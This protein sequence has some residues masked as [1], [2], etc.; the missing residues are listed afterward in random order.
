MSIDNPLRY[1]LQIAG[2]E[3]EVREVIGSEEL[4]GAFRFEVRRRV[5]EGDELNP[6]EL[7][8][9]ELVKGDAVLL[10]RR[11]GL[12]V[13][14]IVA[15]VTDASIEYTLGS[16]AELSLVLEPRLS[17]LNF[18]QDIR[19]FR[20]KD[21]PTIVSEVMSALGVTVVSKLTES[22][23][24]RPYCVQ[25]R[26]TDYHFA[27]RLLEEEGIFYYFDENGAVVL[28]D[29]PGAYHSLAAP[30]T[31]FRQEAAMNVEGA[32]WSI[33]E[34]ASTGVSAITLRDWNPDTPSL[35]MD[36]SAPG[37]CPS[38]REYYDYPGEY[39]TPDGG[40]RFASRL[41]DAHHSEA[42]SQ[43]GSSSR[44]DFAPGY[45]FVL[46]DPPPGISPG[47]RV[48]R[49]VRHRWDRASG[50]FSLQY[51]ASP[52]SQVVRPK[53]RHPEPCVPNLMTGFVT[54]PPGEDIHTD[55]YGRVKV[56]FHWDRLLGRW[57]MDHH[58]Y[59][60]LG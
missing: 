16:A 58:Q 44:A 19:L 11:D 38:G 32:V 35:N 29:N 15:I 3:L 46:S 37:P 27:N 56:Q 33:G 59:T 4:S 13:R 43:H 8:P 49:S 53:I 60:H 55:E 10:L 40:R 57:L 24:V 18:R 34:R 25:L 6:D 22:Y 50:S 28:G 23:P 45:T 1:F 12:V 26:E 21:A 7:D 30:E 51:S 14:R 9:D 42:F 41:A 5:S 17:L 20:D 39:G 52:G 47:E 2:R 48:I 31:P 36:V 54:G